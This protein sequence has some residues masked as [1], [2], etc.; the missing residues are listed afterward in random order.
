M[1]VDPSDGLSTANDGPEARLQAALD[2][3]RV[4]GAHVIEPSA[5]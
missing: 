4:L 3:A 2:R 1:G 5:D